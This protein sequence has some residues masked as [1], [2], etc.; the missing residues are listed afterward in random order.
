MTLTRSKTSQFLTM[1]MTILREFLITNFKDELA[2]AT[3]K[4]RFRLGYIG[5]KNRK[6]TSCNNAYL[7]KAY[8]SVKNGW[9]TLWTDPHQ[10]TVKSKAS[11]TSTSKRS[12][13]QFMAFHANSTEG[14]LRR[15]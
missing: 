11:T 12:S 15:L 10:A 13:S 3:E 14:M 9:L 2:P 5:N 4:D 7:A 6:I 8:S 1:L